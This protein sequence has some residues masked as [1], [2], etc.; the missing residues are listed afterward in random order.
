MFRTALSVALLAGFA[1]PVAAGPISVFTQVRDVGG[2]G[3]DELRLTGLGNLAVLTTGGG[4]NPVVTVPADQTSASQPVVGF[5]PVLS[6]QDRAQYEAQRGTILTIPDTPVTLYAEV[7]N[8]AY[9]GATSDVRQILINAIISGTFGADPGQNSL[10][11]QFINPPVQVNFGQT[12]VTLAYVP[13]HMP[14]GVP[15]IQFEDGSPTIGFPGTTYYPTLLQAQVNVQRD[16]NA[17]GSGDPPV[18][19][20]PSNQPPVNGTPEPTSALLLAGLAFGGFAAR[21]RAMGK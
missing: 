17:S 3:S 12:T 14:V 20:P 15:Q 2:T 6:F 19:Q 18:V 8:G 4:V 9:G 1:A 10:D 21:A 11:W 7:W 5:W 13:I 16:P